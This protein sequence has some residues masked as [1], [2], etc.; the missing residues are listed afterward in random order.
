ML[1]AAYSAGEGE[2]R[3]EAV[4][5]K[6]CASIAGRRPCLPFIHAIKSEL[7]RVVMYCKYV[8]VKD[9]KFP[10]QILLAVRLGESIVGIHV[11]VSGLYLYV[12]GSGRTNHMYV[13]VLQVLG[14]FTTAHL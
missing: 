14:I 8:L 12:L 9:V 6:H 1:A 5:C 3:S 2:R 13:A 10:W 4:G 7:R 11:V